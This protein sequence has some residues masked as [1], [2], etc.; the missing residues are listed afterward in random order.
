MVQPASISLNNTFSSSSG[1]KHKQ[2]DKG[3]IREHAQSNS[4]EVVWNK[5]SRESWMRMERWRT[6]INDVTEASEAFVSRKTRASGTR[7]ES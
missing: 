5:T 4:K 2:F 6:L 1:S 3:G 7:G